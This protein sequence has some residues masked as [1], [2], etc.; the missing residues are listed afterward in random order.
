VALERFAETIRKAEQTAQPPVTPLDDVCV[1]I[2]NHGEPVIYVETSHAYE[3][4]A[5]LRLGFS[6]N[7]ETGEVLFAGKDDAGNNW[8]IRYWPEGRQEKSDRLSPVDWESAVHQT[9]WIP[10]VP[11]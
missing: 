11:A 9:R 8:V 3:W 6:P 5:H 4:A 10:E 7:V 2:N 1:A